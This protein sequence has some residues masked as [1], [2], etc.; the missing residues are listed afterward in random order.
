MSRS[1]SDVEKFASHFHVSLWTLVTV[2]RQPWLYVPI[3][4]CSWS[5]NVF[6][7][8]P[9]WPYL[10]S[11][12]VLEAKEERSA[13]LQYVSS[14][15]IPENI[16]SVCSAHI[17]NSPLFSISHRLINDRCPVRWGV[18]RTSLQQIL[19]LIFLKCCYDS[20]FDSAHM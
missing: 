8:G 2:L 19:L 5:V 17:E 20:Y 11:G 6:K 15:F 7:N 16:P 18:R 10:G 1:P 3:H 4:T 9:V 13:E 14:M 12:P